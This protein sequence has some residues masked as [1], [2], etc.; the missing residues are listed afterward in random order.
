LH[1]EILLQNRTVKYFTEKNDQTKL[2]N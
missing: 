1:D 2:K